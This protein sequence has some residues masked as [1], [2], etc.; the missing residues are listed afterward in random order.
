MTTTTTTLSVTLNGKTEPVEFMQ[1]RADLWI[2]IDSPFACRIG[3]N[4][5]KAHF[6][7][8]N[9]WVVKEGRSTI[10][11][12]NIFEIN[13]S[14][15]RLDLTVTIRNQFAQIIGFRSQF[16]NT[17]AATKQDYYGGEKKSPPSAPSA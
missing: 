10:G 4:G 1:L 3:R 12:A 6:T 17:A 9:L 15:F 7:G 8:A 16:E 14:K 5:S 11:L 2:A 13:G